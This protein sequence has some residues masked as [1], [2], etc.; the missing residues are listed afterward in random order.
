MYRLGGVLTDY[1][2]L[3]PRRRPHHVGLVEVEVEPLNNL[4]RLY[5]SYNLEH[6]A[7]KFLWSKVDQDALSTAAD[8][9]SY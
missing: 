3:V 4:E 7:T 9:S 6:H 5:N 8:S 1:D 2:D